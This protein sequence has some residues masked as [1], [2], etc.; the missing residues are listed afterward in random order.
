[1]RLLGLCLLGL[2]ASQKIYRSCD[3]L[4]QVHKT[5]LHVNKSVSITLDYTVSTQITKGIMETQVYYNYIPFPIYREDLCKRVVCPIRSG[6]HTETYNYT[7]S[8]SGKIQAQIKWF[9]KNNTP[10]LCV[11]IAT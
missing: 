9:D 8:L 3:G 6:R 7:L 4:F 10:L 2:V 11:I 1:M 5:S